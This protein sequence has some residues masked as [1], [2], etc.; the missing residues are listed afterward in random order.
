MSFDNI[1]SSYIDLKK[2]TRQVGELGAKFTDMW[3]KYMY[4]TMMSVMTNL[5]EDN[6]EEAK[7]AFLEAMEQAKKNST[8]MINELSRM[9]AQQVGEA[10]HIGFNEGSQMANSL[11]SKTM[12]KL[13]AD[14]ALDDPD[15][16]IETY[17][18]VADKVHQDAFRE[19]M[20]G[21]TLNLY[22]NNK[23]KE[24]GDV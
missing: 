1:T 13:I 18:K 16:K 2:N 6:E 4:N 7:K 15:G 14:G 17:L 10:Y 3:V 19:M 12:R 23:E 11:N 8:D 24:N 22:T 20:K 21:K 5:A 9:S